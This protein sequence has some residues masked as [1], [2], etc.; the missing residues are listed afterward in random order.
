MK[1]QAPKPVSNK[2]SLAVKESAN[3]KPTV[4]NDIDGNKV[5]LSRYLINNFIAPGSDF[6]DKQCWALINL[7]KARG[8]NPI[9]R[10]CFYVEYDG[11]PQVIVSKDYYL[12]RA[13]K[14]SNYIGKEN[15]IVILNRDGEIEMRVG[16]IK[17][18]DEE[19][20]GGWCKVY[21]KNLSYPVTVTASLKEYAK[22]N[23]DGELQAT[24]KTKTCLMIEKIA[25]VRA[26]KEAMT[27]EFGGTYAAEEFGEAEESIESKVDDIPVNEVKES[28]AAKIVESTIKEAQYV[29]VDEDTDEVTEDDGFDMED[30]EFEAMQNSFFN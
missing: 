14:N 6:T 27:E 20:L 3:E 12:K 17:L 11:K 24:W 23:K 26:L 5:E 18:D 30:A 28:K 19:L 4:Y 2:Q 8:L 21:M 13:C 16:T 25:I 10:D 22:M 7:S 9:A 15:G 1:A 29:E